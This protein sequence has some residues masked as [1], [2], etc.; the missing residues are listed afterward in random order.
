M[1]HTELSHPNH[2]SCIFSNCSICKE[3]K[4]IKLKE[5]KRKQLKENK[6]ILMGL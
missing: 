6:N 5:I 1:Y 4:E 2:A 3:L